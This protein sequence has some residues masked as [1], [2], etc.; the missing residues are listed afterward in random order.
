MKNTIEKQ[1]MQ[2]LNNMVKAG[3]VLSKQLIS[4]EILYSLADNTRVKAKPLATEPSKKWVKV[5]RKKNQSEAAKKAWVTRRK[6]NEVNAA[7]TK[8]STAAHKAWDTRR[9]LKKTTL[10]SA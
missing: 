6:I 2:V 3:T 9:S 5:S 4:G 8:R 10:L 7:K 1:I